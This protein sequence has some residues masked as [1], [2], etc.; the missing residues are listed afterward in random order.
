MKNFKKVLALVLV[1]AT[2]LSFATVAGAVNTTE[3]YADAKDVKYVEAVDVLTAIGV[4]NGKGASYKP[5]D[6]LKRSE[7]AKII[8]MFDNGDTDISKLYDPAN[9]FTDVAKDYWAISYIA[10]CAKQGI[11]SGV[12][13][14]KFAPESKLTGIQFLKMVLVT[15]GYNAKDE[16]LVGTSWKVNVLKLARA[17]GL[18]DV[19]GKKY[20]YD[21]EL[22]RDA[23]A[24]IMLNALNAK[25]VSY[26]QE[27][28]NSGKKTIL[29]TAGAIENASYLYESWDLKKIEDTDDVFGR[30]CHIWKWD[31]KDNNKYVEIGTY[32]DEALATYTEEVSG[33]DI[34]AD[35]DFDDEGVKLTK[36]VDGVKSG[37]ETIK[38]TDDKFGGQGTLTQVYEDRIVYINT[39]LAK[40]T[41]VT[42]EK[43]DSKGH[44]TRKANTAM[45]AYLDIPATGRFATTGLTTTALSYESEDFAKDDM[46]LVTIAGTKKEVQTIA[47]AESKV[48]E[49]SKLKK[50]NGTYSEIALDGDYSKIAAKY[51]YAGIDTDNIGD[52]MVAYFDT[53]GN[54]IGMEKYYAALNYAV[55]DALWVESV[56]GKAVI[57]ADLVAVNGDKME[58]VEVDK[59]TLNASTSYDADKIVADAG[60]TWQNA[61]VFAGSTYAKNTFYDKLMAYTTDDG[62]YTLTMKEGFASYYDSPVKTVDFT[63]TTKKEVTFT[64]GSSYA[65]VDNVVFQMSDST[66]VLVRDVDSK[67]PFASYTAYEGFD[68]IP[69]M[70][71]TNV[72]YVIN[73]DTKK[74]DVV[75]VSGVSVTGKST[76]IFYAGA[77]VD[78]ASKKDDKY[79]YTFDAY[80][81]DK[82]TGALTSDSFTYKTATKDALKGLAVGFY[83]IHVDDDKFVSF[84]DL[85]A[86]TSKPKLASDA[87][88]IAQ[89]VAAVKADATGDLVTVSG[90]VIDKEV[91]DITTYAKDGSALKD[92]TFTDIA[93]GDTLYVYKNADN[94]KFTVVNAAE[95]A[96][97]KFFAGS[98]EVAANATEQTVGHSWEAMTIASV[99]PGYLKTGFTVKMY[100]NEA[101]TTGEVTVT[102]PTKDD[103]TVT[104]KKYIKVTL[105]ADP[106]YTNTSFVTGSD[107]TDVV[108]YATVSGSTITL[109]HSYTAGVLKAE[110]TKALASEGASLEIYSSVNVVAEAG[111]TLNNTYFV[112]VTAK[113][114]ATTAT[115]SIA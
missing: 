56:K 114:G 94:G 33:C 86:G 20:D 7:A 73:S 79:Q 19:L 27:L 92:A 107:W 44:V 31:E 23:A 43:T 24:Q 30:P 67:V 16:G 70:T 103:K 95:M 12:G 84:D 87:A 46:V 76:V 42:T 98:T 28:K 83:N 93:N 15:L 90:I 62:V 102:D 39:Y 53:Y 38:N 54:I 104:V 48:A 34:I 110:L 57:K 68:A 6:T 106:D 25:T 81:L 2:L 72:Q 21:A 58:D 109:N 52:D 96:T 74:A 77:D 61:Q 91:A 69:S 40:V 18:T 29:T 4:L 111:E 32:A 13:N 50:V 78:Q 113:D 59:I 89:G 82:S 37:T 3:I 101:M 80:V 112:V 115:Y 9:P 45:D 47:L 99:E 88:T 41:K 60:A 63:H 26:G 10:Y 1:V 11:I 65:K 85:D 100:D 55:I 35:A 14:N 17:A 66:L 49:F 8:A 71:A 36:W 64:N 108:T 75:Y 51:I 97:I 105:A 22:T 5:N